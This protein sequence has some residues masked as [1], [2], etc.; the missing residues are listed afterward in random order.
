M[1]GGFGTQRSR[2]R[3]MKGNYPFGKHLWVL[4]LEEKKRA[5]N[6][7]SVLPLPFF[8]FLSFDSCNSFSTYVLVFFLRV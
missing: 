2:W 4:F 3:H 8:V 1:R 6:A 7:K 5:I